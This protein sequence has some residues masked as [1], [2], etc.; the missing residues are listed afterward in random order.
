MEVLLVIE[1]TLVGKSS[2]DDTY[3]GDLWDIERLGPS[4]REDVMGDEIEWSERKRV[5]MTRT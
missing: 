4:D 2:K 1:S 5:I 3:K